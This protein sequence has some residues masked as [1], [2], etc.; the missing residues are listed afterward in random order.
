MWI[1]LWG[2]NIRCQIQLLVFFGI[3]LIFTMRSLEYNLVYH[4]FLRY[5]KESS[6]IFYEFPFAIPL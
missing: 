5:P 1:N 4:L 2:K 6:E 3:L